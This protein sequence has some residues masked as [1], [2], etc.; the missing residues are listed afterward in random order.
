MSVKLINQ[1]DKLSFMNYS[2]HSTVTRKG[3][4]AAKCSKETYQ[5]LQMGLAGRRRLRNQSSI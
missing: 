5:E 2:P 3:E 1:P 4:T